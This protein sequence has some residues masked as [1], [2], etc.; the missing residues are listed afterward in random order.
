MSSLQTLEVS[1]LC[2]TQ[3]QSLNQQLLEIWSMVGLFS[4][5]VYFQ[6]NINYVTTFAL[7]QVVSIY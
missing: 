4:H 5:Y 1:Q 3:Y 7:G 2:D 6:D